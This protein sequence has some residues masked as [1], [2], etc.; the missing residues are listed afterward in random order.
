M[1][2]QLINSLAIQQQNHYF[3][4]VL[5]LPVRQ[6]SAV[7]AWSLYFHSMESVLWDTIVSILSPV[8][9]NSDMKLV[10]EFVQRLISSIR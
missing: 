10:E 9:F 1:S 2:Q 4:V 8:L 5:L 6:I 3:M 7:A